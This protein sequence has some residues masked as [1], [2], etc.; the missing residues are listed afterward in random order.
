HGGPTPPA[1]RPARD[2][3]LRTGHPGGLVEG[4]LPGRRHD[5]GWSA[6]RGGG[7]VLRGADG[8]GGASRLGVAA[9]AL[10]PD[11]GGAAGGTGPAR[12]PARPGGQEPERRLAARVDAPRAGH[13]PRR[14][15]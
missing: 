2:E 8:R 14:P 9:E 4:L 6:A 1:L 13:V 12:P 11:D 15:L 3:P 5:E 7:A 10:A